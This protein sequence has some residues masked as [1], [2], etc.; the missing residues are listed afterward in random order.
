MNEMLLRADEAMSRSGIVAQLD[1]L[2]QTKIV[3]AICD[4]RRCN[5][6]EQL[7]LQGA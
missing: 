3:L 5:K 4:R 6:V 2:G 1:Q 7:N